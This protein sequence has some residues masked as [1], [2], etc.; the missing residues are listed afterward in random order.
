MRSFEAKVNAKGRITIPAKLRGIWNL[1]R[2][3]NVEF[4]FSHMNTLVVRPRSANPSA[5][6]ENA[7]KRKA[8]TRDRK[9]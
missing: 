6:S 9:K 2:G 5:V 7:P 1:K 4:Y 8:L 3:D